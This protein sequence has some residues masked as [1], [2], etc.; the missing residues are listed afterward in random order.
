[1]SWR[2]VVRPEVEMD[3][4]VAATWYE[5]Q[6]SGLGSEFVGEVLDV[7]DTLAE[8]PLGHS[9]RVSLKNVRWCYPNRFPYRVIYE[10]FPEDNLVVIA[11]VIHAARHDRH[12]SKRV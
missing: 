6:C 7:F 10:V 8:N 5:D 11:C 12:W 4:A 1:M 3:V 2:V 9:R